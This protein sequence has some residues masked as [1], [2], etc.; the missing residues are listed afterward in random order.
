V[1]RRRRRRPLPQGHDAPR[2]MDGSDG[3]SSSTP[4]RPVHPIQ[5]REKINSIRSFVAVSHDWVVEWSGN[6]LLCIQ[7]LEEDKNKIRSS[8]TNQWTGFMRSCNAKHSCLFFLPPRMK[9]R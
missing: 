7:K 1:R 5:L 9:T 8:N 2:L 6:S 3:S 4:R